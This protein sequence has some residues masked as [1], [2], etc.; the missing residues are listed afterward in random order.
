MNCF[1]GSLSFL[2]IFFSFALKRG[3]KKKRVEDNQLSGSTGVTNSP[4]LPT[5]LEGADLGLI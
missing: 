4:V 1:A 2:G 3:K 5:W